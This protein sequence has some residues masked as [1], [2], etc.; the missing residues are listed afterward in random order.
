[1]MADQPEMS[2]E[3]EDIDDEQDKSLNPP[4]NTT[5][6]QT[7][8][9]EWTKHTKKLSISF[10]RVIEIEALMDV[11]KKLGMEFAEAGKGYNFWS[12]DNYKSYHYDPTENKMHIP[13][14]SAKSFEIVAKI[15]LGTGN[16]SFDVSALTAG[17]N[18][19]DK[20]ETLFNAYKGAKAADPNFEITGLSDNLK[21][22]FDKRTAQQTPSLQPH[23]R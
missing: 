20:E 6:A 19:K 12:M 17:M 13:D 23:P 9:P 14:T 15:M 5:L 1:M 10:E 4:T 21:Q 11:V 16:S 3:E 7:P 2:P 8:K 22:E 18:K